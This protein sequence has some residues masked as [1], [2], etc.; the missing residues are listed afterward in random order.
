LSDVLQMRQRTFGVGI[1]FP[2]MSLVT[3]NIH[4]R[5]LLLARLA[6]ELLL[7]FSTF[8]H[9]RH[10]EHGTTQR[11]FRTYLFFMS[12]MERQVSREKLQPAARPREVS[13]VPRSR[14]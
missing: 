2:A 14:Q 13:A 12:Q 3:T 1:A 7:E 4:N 6:Y 5:Y 10:A 9:C 11:Y 8:N